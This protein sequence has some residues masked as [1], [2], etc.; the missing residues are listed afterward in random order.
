M[1][2]GQIQ[3]DLSLVIVEL[4]FKRVR[5]DAQY[6]KF[7]CLVET[8]YLLALPPAEHFFVE[9]STVEH[10]LLD[11]LQDQGPGVLHLPVFGPLHGVL[12]KT[13]FVSTTLDVQM[14]ENEINYV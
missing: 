9:F 11:V 1:L 3:N 2:D 6:V 8:K 13:R 4:V 12:D 14:L 7:A 5:E 10:G